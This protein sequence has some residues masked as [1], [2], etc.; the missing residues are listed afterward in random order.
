VFSVLAVKWQAVILNPKVIDFFLSK[1]KAL[2][3]RTF[4]LFGQKLTAVIIGRC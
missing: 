3:R 4:P 2:F 1:N